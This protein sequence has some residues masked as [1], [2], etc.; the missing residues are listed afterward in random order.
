MRR[1]AKLALFFAHQW[2]PAKLTLALIMLSKLLDLNRTSSMISA[3]ATVPD[4]PLFAVLLHATML[5]RGAQD[6]PLGS[7]YSLM[8]GEGGG[9]YTPRLPA[10]WWNL[11][12]V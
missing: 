10:A 1:R 12:V 5:P 11:T 9:A 6:Y 2:P 3:L 4:H 8:W 7:S